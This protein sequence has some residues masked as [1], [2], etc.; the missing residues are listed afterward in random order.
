M[1]NNL[2]SIIV[3]A[4]NAAQRIE[5]T[6]NSLINQTYKNLEI[7]IVND[8]STDMTG[9]ILDRLAKKDERL[10][11]IHLRDNVGVYK[12]RAKG[13]EFASAKWIGFLDADDYSKPEMF[14]RML[15]I[16]D[17]KEVDVVICES[18]RVDNK[19]KK[20]SSKVRFQDNIKI[21][22]NIFEKFC[23]FEFGTGAHWNKLYKAELI[24][25]WGTIDYKLRQDTNE[26]LLV[27]IGVFHNA[28]S[29]YLMKEVLHE[30]SYNEQSVTSSLNQCNAYYSIIKAYFLAIT[31][32]NNFDANAYGQITSLY[33]MQ[34]EWSDYTPT[35]IILSK[36][37]T[38]QL[39]PLISEAM[40]IYPNSM[41]YL[42]CRR[43]KEECKFQAVIKKIIKNLYFKF[44]PNKGF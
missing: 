25:K 15:M 21:T 29:V 14:K 30:Y 28:K 35:D 1:K 7:I 32:Y 36:E 42:L 12:A 41:L 13:I 4:Y 11:I 22:N 26:D 10:K 44:I 33:R 34:L 24:K 16:A 6:L 17:E 31:V 23:N 2:I 18:D 5:G 8:A 43:P 19:R 40:E 20:I 9:E 38:N 39:L 27:N 3:P 37:Q